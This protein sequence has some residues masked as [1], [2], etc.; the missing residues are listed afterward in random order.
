MNEERMAILSMVAEGK[1]TV[2]EAEALLQ[3]LGSPEETQPRHQ[4]KRKERR[5]RRE[6]RGRRP[7]RPP[8]P[9]RAPRV[10]EEFIEGMHRFKEGMGHFVHDVVNDVVEG[11]QEGFE[12]FEFEFEDFDEAFDTSPQ[13][14]TV[15][16]ETS[17]VIKNEQGSLTI[18]GTDEPVLSVSGAP[19]QHYKLQH[20]RNQITIKS[21]RFGAALTVHVPRNVTQLGVKSQLSAVVAKNFHRLPRD[22]QIKTQT[23]NIDLELGTIAEGRILLKTQTGRVRLSLSEQSAFDLKASKAIGEIETGYPLE[24]IEQGPGYLYGN[25]NG[26]GAKIRLATQVGHIEIASALTSEVEQDEFEGEIS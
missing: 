16:P 9:P 6:R 3:S 8:R 5:E 22:I 4:Y 14:I 15:A 12:A 25:R 20:H 17:L 26:G 11:V 7:P 13:T 1:I 10:P 19:R 21:T 18:I 2:D 23:G 24:V